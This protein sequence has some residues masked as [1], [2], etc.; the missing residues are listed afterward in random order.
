MQNT[1]STTAP[2]TAVATAPTIELALQTVTA[3]ST[4][5]PIPHLRLV[6][7][8]QGANSAQSVKA[9]M[10]AKN[11]IQQF[12]LSAIRT[13]GNV[14]A[15]I[16]V[17]PVVTAEYAK[18]MTEGVLFLPVVLF[19]DGNDHWLADGFYR[20]SAA[21]SLERT[22]IS[23]QIHQG[24]QRDAQLFA[25]AANN[26]HGERYTSKDK[27]HAVLTLLMDAE[28]NGW[29]NYQIARHCGVTEGTV[30]KYRETVP[31]PA[32]NTQTRRFLR[33]GKELEMNISNHAPKPTARLEPTLK[34]VPDMV[35]D[36]QVLDIAVSLP[37]IDDLTQISLLAALP[38]SEQL[39]VVQS[40]ER[41]QKGGRLKTMAD[42]ISDLRKKQEKA[43]KDAARQGRIE[44][45][46]EAGM[47]DGFVCGD[48]THVLPGLEP[49]SVRLLLADG[50]YGIGYQSRAFGAP[51]RIAND[52]TPEEALDIHRRMLESI[53]PAM[54]PD[55]HVMLFCD[56]KLE[57]EFRQ[58]L[59]EAGYEYKDSLIWDKGDCGRPIPNQA[60]RRHERIL[61][62]TK[63]KP[64]LTASISD[65][66]CF[67]RSNRS[68]NAPDTS[69]LTPKPV[70]LLSELI[71]AATVAGERVV[72]PFAGSASTLVAAKELG[73]GYFGVEMNPDWHAEGMARLLRAEV[74]P[75]ASQETPILHLVPATTQL[76]KLTSEVGFCADTY[77][78]GALSIA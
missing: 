9:S 62:F 4:V 34:L 67:P 52:A 74:Q 42:A 36:P 27:R 14:R 21:T 56:K 16:D 50:P 25:I 19:F 54:M 45:A 40:I 63:G 38:A 58:L 3:T 51:E 72:D 69:H 7:N 35:I 59:L 2:I 15:R 55:S 65:V 66:L 33:G 48:C 78:A 17:N 61:W 76:S 68:G 13:D 71:N 5:T 77:Q 32:Q 70:A 26:A 30:R 46:L 29:S 10:Q 64:Q 11:A 22:Q 24:S 60:F 28:W 44:A 20:V 37:F 18:L 23:A 75:Q 43:V 31:A 73:R 47:D 53:E 6:P 49:Q 12:A 1:I 41:S 57:P 39:E 8:S